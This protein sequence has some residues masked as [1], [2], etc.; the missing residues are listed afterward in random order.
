VNAA[1]AQLDEPIRQVV[2]LHYIGGLSLRQ[3]AESM[4]I[5]KGTVK[6]R[7]NAALTK[8]RSALE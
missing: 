7:L 5:A 8:L 1:I 6:S 2:I 3:T 4:G